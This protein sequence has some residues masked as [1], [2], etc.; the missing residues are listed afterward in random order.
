MT[1][2]T[3]ADSFLEALAVHR[4]APAVT[5]GVSMALFERPIPVALM[6]HLLFCELESERH[7]QPIDPGVAL[8]GESAYRRSGKNDATF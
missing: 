5:F 8:F 2:V 4:L 6:R 7:E 1:R 3:T